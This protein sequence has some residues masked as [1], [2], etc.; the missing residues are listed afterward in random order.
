MQKIHLTIIAVTVV[1]YAMMAIYSIPQLFRFAG[2][3][4]P[5]DMRIMGYDQ[6]AAQLYLDTITPEG[7]LFYLEVQQ[8]LD[9]YFP[10]LLALSLILTL[11]RLAPRLPILFAFPVIAAFIDYTENALV[12]DILLSDRV[13]GDLVQ[14]ASLMTGLKYAFISLTILTILFLWRRGKT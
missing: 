4:W 13:P 5:F 1:N 8:M 2:G 6:A 11:Y 12:G 9:T 10:A 7:R 3:L 14:L